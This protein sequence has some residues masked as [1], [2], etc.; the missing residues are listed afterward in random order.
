MILVNHQGRQISI[1]SE[2]CLLDGVPDSIRKDGRAMRTLLGRIK[3]NPQEK[4]KSIQSML[5]KLFGMSKWAEWDIKVDKKP[6][7]LESRRLAAPQLDHTSFGTQEVYANE[8]NLKT[9]PVYSCN[10]LKNSTLMIFHDRYSTQEAQNALKNLSGCCR[11]MELEVG[12]FETYQVPDLR[13]FDRYQGA[14]RDVIDDFE[15]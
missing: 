14:V 13:D 10:D 3:Q 6:Q 15:K 9:I 12:N 8:R 11:Q 1:P 4:M 7:L 2:F 5:E